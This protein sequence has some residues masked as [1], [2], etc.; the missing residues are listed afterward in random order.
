[1]PVPMPVGAVTRA[2]NLAAGSS[3]AESSFTRAVNR[4]ASFTSASIRFLNQAV[5]LNPATNRRFPRVPMARTLSPHPRVFAPV[6]G[7][8]ETFRPPSA[9]SSLRSVPLSRINFEDGASVQSFLGGQPIAMSPTLSSSSSISSIIDGPWPEKG[10]FLQHIQELKGF[11]F[12]KMHSEVRLNNEAN[13]AFLEERYARLSDIGAT[14]D[15]IVLERYDAIDGALHSNYKDFVSFFDGLT[16]S[17]VD[18][19]VPDEFN[20][21]VLS[22]RGR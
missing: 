21:Y 3:N 2:N 12:H 10:E 6:S 16:G 5:P 4:A 8:A 13:V 20:N 22:L 15:S 18:L 11:I 1:M 7:G 9:G 17:A 14:V 19:N